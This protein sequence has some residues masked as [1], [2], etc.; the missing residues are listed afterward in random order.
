MPVREAQA[1]G[2][3][4]ALLEA[5]LQPECV[6]DAKADVVSEPEPVRLCDGLALALMEGEDVAL[7]LPVPDGQCEVDGVED[8][9]LEAQLL[10]LPDVS[11][12]AVWLSDAQGEG[13]R[14]ALEETEAL[15]DTVPQEDK[16]GVT[17]GLPVMEDVKHGDVVAPTDAEIEGELVGEKVTE[18]VKH[19][20]GLVEGLL[21]TDK[22]MDGEWVGD[23]V[24]LPLPQALRVDVREVLPLTVTVGHCDTE[25][26]GDGD[27]ESVLDT[28]PVMV[29]DADGEGEEAIEPEKEPEPELEMET[30]G[31]IEKVI[32]AVVGMALR[33]AQPV[34][35]VVTL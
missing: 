28:L 21:V 1:D 8:R 12:E 7:M 9:E 29:D 5:E 27:G 24:P 35:D 26:L 32:P 20:V 3:L 19:N 13:E 15:K 6:G 22:V 23:S 14:D 30:V 2:E 33:E 4:V 10:T 16:D 17:E 25:R 31:L 18:A 34:E 11:A